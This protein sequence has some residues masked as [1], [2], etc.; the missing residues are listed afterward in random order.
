MIARWDYY[1]ETLV[2]LKIRTVLVTCQKNTQ[3]FLSKKNINIKNIYVSVIHTHIMMSQDVSELLSW[4]QKSVP[5]K[6]NVEIRSIFCV[7]PTITILLTKNAIFLKEEEE[8]NKDKIPD[9]L[10]KKLLS[11]K[12]K[13]IIITYLLWFLFLPSRKKNCISSL[14]Q[15]LKKCKI[16]NISCTTY[17]YYYLTKKYIDLSFFKDIFWLLKIILFWPHHILKLTDTDPSIWQVFH[18]SC[19]YMEKKIGNWAKNFKN[20]KRNL[21]KKQG[22]YIYIYY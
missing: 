2:V 1:W 21:K 16:Q 11:R 6:K 3:F 15:P 12:E 4:F 10:T 17:Y 7:L 8:E 13:H 18:Y 9:T 22:I 20:R 5:R 19:L 14:N